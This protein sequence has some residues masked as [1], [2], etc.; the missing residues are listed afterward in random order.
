MHPS[1]KFPQPRRFKV[2]IPARGCKFISR[3]GAE[4]GGA[5]TKHERT[6]PKRTK[7]QN[8][9]ATKGPRNKSA[10]SEREPNRNENKPKPQKTRRLQC[11]FLNSSTPALWNVTVLAETWQLLLVAMTRNLPR[12]HS[13][14]ARTSEGKNGSMTSIL[15]GNAPC[16]EI[17]QYC[18]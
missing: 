17:R 14:T 16:F 13:R 4:G 1:D 8:Q 11:T 10:T 12:L 2:Y 5:G 9:T 7:D 15:L 18:S 3:G 6:K